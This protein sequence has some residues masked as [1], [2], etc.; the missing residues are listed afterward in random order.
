MFKW[1]AALLM[2]TSFGSFAKDPVVFKDGY[3]FEGIL[4]GSTLHVRTVNISRSCGYDTRVNGV[5]EDMG[6]FYTLKYVCW[7]LPRSSTTYVD[8]SYF[9]EPDQFDLVYKDREGKVIYE[10][11]WSAKDVLD[12]SQ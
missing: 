2:L 4:T 7:S 8:L 5:D 10:G 11:I 9:Y 1:L 6:R 3:L 12:V